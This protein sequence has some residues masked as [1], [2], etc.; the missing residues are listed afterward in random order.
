LRGI[1]RR[2]DRYLRVLIETPKSFKILKIKKIVL[3]E[4]NNDRDKK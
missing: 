3:N 4:M 1:Q 2:Y